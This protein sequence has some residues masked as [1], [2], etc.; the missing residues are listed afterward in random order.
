MEVEDVVGAGALVEVVDV[1][2]DDIDPEVLLELD[3]GAVAGV[4][5]GL[6]QVV[7]AFVVEAVD[8]GVSSSVQSAVLA[9]QGIH[10]C[11][12]DGII[13]KDIEKTIENLGSVGSTGM[14]M[15]D[16]LIQKIMVHK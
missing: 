12:T 16:S 3:D 14:E 6:D 11:E 4:G 13:D 7:A 5:L 2:C 10:A 15:A 9:L 1:L 8:E